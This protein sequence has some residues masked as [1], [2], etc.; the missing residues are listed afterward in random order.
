MNH[1]Q[2]PL[3]EP[4]S[5][6]LKP[7]LR[8][9][10]S[11][12]Y[13]TASE[14]LVSFPDEWEVIGSIKRDDQTLYVAGLDKETEQPRR[15]HFYGLSPEVNMALTHYRHYKLFQPWPMPTIVASFDP[16][17]GT[18]EVIGGGHLKV[19]LREIGQA[20]AWSGQQAAVVWECYCS[21]LARTG[22]TKWQEELAAFWQAVEGDVSTDNGDGKETSAAT[23]TDTTPYTLYTQPHEPTFEEGYEE[24]L[25]RLGYAPD[26]EF[27]KW[28]SKHK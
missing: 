2:S 22:N 11:L 27:P 13:P 5:T 21:E 8:T 26:T 7:K 3:P 20:Q 14:I 15:D 1:E 4:L 19:Q 12:D 25:G 28:W 10:V 23:T 18:G 17:T 16:A 9:A 6:P 24:F